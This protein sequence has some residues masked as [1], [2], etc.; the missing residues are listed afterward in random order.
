MVQHCLW[1]LLQIEF[2]LYSEHNQ[3]H[4]TFVFNIFIRVKSQ[5]INLGSTHVCLVF[6]YSFGQK[7]LHVHVNDL[8]SKTVVLEL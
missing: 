1:T 3:I 4:I 6:V 5:L 2:P 8:S 7:S